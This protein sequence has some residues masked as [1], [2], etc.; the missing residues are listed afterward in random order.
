[1]ARWQP[2]TPKESLQASLDRLDNRIKAKRKE[3]SELEAQ[4]K[5]VD[6]AIKAM[7]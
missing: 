5:Q 1:M 4:K 6:Q 3:I 7:G 2:R